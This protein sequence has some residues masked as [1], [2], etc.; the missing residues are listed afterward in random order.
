MNRIL[1]EGGRGKGS[2]LQKKDRLGFVLWVKG[3]MA[4]GGVSGGGKREGSP[5]PGRQ[6]GRQILQVGQVIQR[7][8]TGR[9]GD[10]LGDGVLGKGGGRGGALLCLGGEK[11]DQGGQGRGASRQGPSA[12]RRGRGEGEAIWM[13][14][15]SCRQDSLAEK[16]GGGWSSRAVRS[17]WRRGRE[18]SSWNKVVSRS[19][20]CAA[21][22]RAEEVV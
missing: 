6:R 18:V 16:A 10:N 9:R 22:R 13:V 12:S 7:R 14:A 4:R 1:G 19:K 2:V 17:A 5:R 20:R 15:C 3:K 11:E 21:A 8:Q